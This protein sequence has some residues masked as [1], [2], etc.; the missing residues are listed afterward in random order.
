MSK[1]LKTPCINNE[2]LIEA[3]S[4]ESYLDERKAIDIDPVLNTAE[5]EASTVIEDAK[6]KAQEILQS[7]E[8][9]LKNKLDEGYEIGQQQGYHEGMEKA[10]LEALIRYEE[11]KKALLETYEMRETIIK[12]LEKDLSRLAISIAEKIIV[13]Q[14]SLAPETIVDIVKEACSHFRQAD[15]ITIFVNPEDG[16]LLRQRKT[17]IQEALGE[18]CRVYIIDESG[19]SQGSC[20]L[21]SENG[22]IDAGL[23]AQLENMGIAILGAE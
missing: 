4:R 5:K 6:N 3:S 23:K 20:M 8:E 7:A 13:K 22:L 12:D 19:L 9:Q 17:E 1:L 2:V 21:E 18:Y 14:L 10:R 11:I 15:Q 16:Y